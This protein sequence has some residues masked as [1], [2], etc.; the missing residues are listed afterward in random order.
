MCCVPMQKQC[1]LDHDALSDQNPE[2]TFRESRE[3][4]ILY[5][6]PKLPLL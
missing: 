3:K 6:R 4:S 1:R 2:G 5:Q